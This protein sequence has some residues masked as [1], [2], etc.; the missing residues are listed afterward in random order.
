MRWGRW[1][2]G[3]VAALVTAFSIRDNTFTP[4]GSD[5]A[6]YVENAHRWAE[7]R[8]FEPSPLPL[9]VEWTAGGALAAPFG[10]RPGPISG[11]DVSEYPAG[12]PV[13][14]AAGLRVAGEDGVYLVAP[15]AAG[16]LVLCAFELAARLAGLWAGVLAAAM[17]TLSPIVLVSAVQPMS[18]GPAAALWLVALVMAARPGPAAAM[19]AGAAAGMAILI[20]PNL[21]PLAAIVGAQLM[22]TAKALGGWRAAF[23][24]GILFGSTTAVGVG[25]LLWTQATLYG[26]PFTPSYRSIAGWF[27]REHIAPNVAIHTRYLVAVHSRWIATAALAP[28]VFLRRAAANEHPPGVRPLAAA[29]VGMILANAASYLPYTPYDDPEY[30]RFFLP[31]LVLAFVL[32]SALTAWTVR[33]IATRSRWVASVAVIPAL[34]VLLTPLPLLRYPF[35]L[36]GAWWRVVSMGRYLQAALPP[37]AVAFAYL[38]S[39]AVAFYTSAPIVR[40]D[41]VP[42]DALDRMVAELERHGYTP[43]FV[44]D[45]PDLAWLRARF[46]GRF[47]ALDWPE[48]ARAVN[49]G[50]IGYWLASD[51][52]RHRRGEQWPTDV[53][54][55]TP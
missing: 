10:I 41:L 36:R 9:T 44:A 35:T 22:A 45:E 3:L 5:P 51:R 17:A 12:M 23:N 37:H 19:A 21:A 7:G 30:L 24:A 55:L 6:A 39:T 50:E 1:G 28:L 33:A 43:V 53:L 18:D 54:R 25:T 31:A 47:G 29:I 42:P 52:D 8:L 20:R 16:V 48:R 49:I 26:G 2:V 38:Q 40:L 32:L 11:T 34:V 4:W 13:L 14:M 46:S 27:T 15:V